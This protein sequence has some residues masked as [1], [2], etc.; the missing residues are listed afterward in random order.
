MCAVCRSERYVLLVP[1]QAI[2]SGLLHI[3]ERLSW[4]P[5][6]DASPPPDGQPPHADPI[7]NDGAFGQCRY[8]ADHHVP[9]GP[10]DVLFSADCGIGDSNEIWC[11]VLL[12]AP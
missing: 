7:R 11:T 5:G 10:E 1:P 2:G 12:Q 4:I 9:E 6:G 8:L 3:H